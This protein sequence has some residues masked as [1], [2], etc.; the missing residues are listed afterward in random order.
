M[1]LRRLFFL[2]LSSL[3]GTEHHVGVE[4]GE[5]GID[6]TLTEAA[7]LAGQDGPLRRH[8]LWSSPARAVVPGSEKGVAPPQGL[9]DLRC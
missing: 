7:G 3:F 8:P 5:Q 9:A 2:R 6:V 4:V 1:R